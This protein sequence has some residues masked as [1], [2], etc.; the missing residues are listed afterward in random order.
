MTLMHIWHKGSRWCQLDHY[1]VTTDI[2][3]TLTPMFQSRQRKHHFPTSVARRWKLPA[4]QCL[5][6][7]TWQSGMILWAHTAKPVTGYTTNARRLWFTLPTVLISCP[8]TSTS[9]CKSVYKIHHSEACC[10]HLV[11]D[12]WHHFLLKWDTSLGARVG[13]NAN[14]SM[15]TMFLVRSKVRKNKVPDF[16]VS[17]LNFK[18]FLAIYIPTTA[19]IRQFSGFSTHGAWILLGMIKYYF[20]LTTFLH[21]I[22]VCRMRWLLAILRS[23]F[24]SSLLCTFSCHPFPPIILPS[25]LT[26]SCHLFLGLPLDL[27]IPKFIYNTLLG[28]LFSSIL[29]THPNQR[30]LF[31]LIVSIIVG[32]SI[33]HKF[34]YWLISSN[35]LFYCHILA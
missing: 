1:V 12:T 11:T 14:M 17:C 9:G 10:H 15:I 24:H 8:V 22:G 3:P 35:F 21:S 20:K 4:R 34:L 32:F 33:L 28:I 19:Y 25:S 2:W 23:F 30:K 5:P 27:V 26:S 18:I 13:T 29:C 7:I 16:S 31:N 6:Q